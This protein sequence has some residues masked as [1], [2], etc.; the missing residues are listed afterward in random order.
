M[1]R[2]SWWRR[3]S[4]GVV[5]VRAGVLHWVLGVSHLVAGVKCVTGCGRK[6]IHR[7]H[8]VYAQHLRARAGRDRALF[9]K[10]F[11]DERG[12]VPVCH[13]CHASHHNA[14]DRIPLT[15]L[16]DSVFEFAAEVLGGPAA[17]EYLTRRYDVNSDSRI[18]ALISDTRSTDEYAA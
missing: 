1:V 15:V 17:W 7:H 10:W 6:A 14:V 12:L 3:D 8:C 11:K 18:D 5:G 13:R 16:P 2:P 9:R 4:A